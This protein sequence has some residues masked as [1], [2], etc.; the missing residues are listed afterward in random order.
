MMLASLLI[1]LR[2]L[3]PL[4]FGGDT[5][6]GPTPNLLAIRVGRAETIAKGVIE[7]AVILVENG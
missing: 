4:C 3:P 7:H 1:P 5:K 2:P 6:P